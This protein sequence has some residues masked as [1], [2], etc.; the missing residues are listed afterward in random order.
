MRRLA[1]VLTLVV[2]ATGVA[3]QTGPLADERIP[4]TSQSQDPD[5]EALA[6]PNIPA[7]KEAFKQMDARRGDVVRSL[8]EIA[9]TKKPSY[10]FYDPRELAIRLL[11][12][13][14]AAEAVD[15]LIADIRFSPP[16]IVDAI[17]F[18]Q[19]Y[20]CAEA[21]VQIGDPAREALLRR[22]NQMPDQ[23]D[24]KIYVL[25]LQLVERNWESGAFRIAIE[26]RQA[27]GGRKQYLEEL[28]GEYHQ[29]QYV[30]RAN[31]GSSTISLLRSSIAE[32]PQHSGTLLRIA[33]DKS[34]IVPADAAEAV[35]LLG[36][37]R[38]PRA[39]PLL[40]ENILV[41]GTDGD[42]AQIED[43]YPAVAALVRIGYPSVQAILRSG[44]RKPRTDVEQRLMAH[45]VAQVLGKRLG[46]MAVEE[47]LATS[48]LPATERQRLRQFAARY[49]PTAIQK[50]K[51]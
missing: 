51:R 11:G 19:Q 42:S 31:A 14:R 9:R 28:L 49:F 36:E 37:V 22:V 5:L 44:F 12:K 21:L 32:I 1:V 41:P 34:L 10:T 39:A 7:R 40:V 29:H 16:M 38:E 33:G 17:S 50:L 6:N 46:A 20:P 25:V 35:K 8:I 2:C 43:Q 27:T 48:S 18:L 4:K 30:P 45:V 24:L 23:Q 15:V 13:L 47:R 26:L 3:Y